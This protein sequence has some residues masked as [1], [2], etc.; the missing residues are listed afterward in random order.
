MALLVVLITPAVT[1]MRFAM[2]LIIGFL[3]PCCGS[4]LVTNPSPHHTD[5]GLADDY[6][7]DGGY[8]CDSGT[9][10]LNKANKYLCCEAD[11]NGV[12][13]VPCNKNYANGD[14]G[15]AFACCPEEDSCTY[16]DFV[17]GASAVGHAALCCPPGT[18]GCA[19]G[20]SGNGQGEC[21]TSD[22]ICQSMDGVGSRCGAL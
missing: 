18:S 6:C 11:E 22:Q 21:C 4:G 20:L 16:Y 8:D 15:F 2:V 12:P 14:Y 10:L 1:V 17:K 13:T 19:G 7:Y 5:R 9:C 3:Y